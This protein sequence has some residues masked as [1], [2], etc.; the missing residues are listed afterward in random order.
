MGLQQLTSVGGEFWIDNNDLLTDLFPN[1]NLTFV[2]EYLYIINNALLTNLSG[3]ENIDLSSI[4]ELG[5]YDNPMLSECDAQSICD[6]LVSPNGTINIHDNASGCNS[7]TEVED[8]CEDN[9][10]PEGIEFE[11]QSSIDNFQSNYPG[12]TEIE[13]DVT[14]GK[15]MISSNITNLDGLNVITAIGGYLDIR[16][17][18]N[19]INLN[20]LSNLTTVG[21]LV[22]IF[23]NNALTDLSGLDLLTNVG[24]NLYISYNDA[25]TNLAGLESLLF[26]GGDLDIRENGSLQSLIGLNSLT[27]IEGSLEIRANM[28]LTSLSEL[29]GLIS[30]GNHLWIGGNDILVSLT[31]LEGISTLEGHLLINYNYG[32]LE[33]TGL[34]NLT[35]IRGYLELRDN[36]VLPNLEGLDNLVSIGG[37]M[38]MRN[39]DALESITALNGLTSIGA[40]FRVSDNDLLTSLSG[41]EN[42]EA[43]SISDLYIHDN[44]VLTSCDIE[45][46]CNYLADPNGA[47]YINNNAIG[48]YDQEEV[49]EACFASVE[50]I[51][52]NEH[53]SISPNPALGTTHLRYTIYEQACLPARQGFTIFELFH[54]SGIKI[55]TILNEVKTPGTYELEVDLN[56]LPPGVYF[57]TLK[58]NEGMLTRKIIKL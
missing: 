24:E 50:E 5:I 41:L 8:D 23:N 32:L 25:L 51:G 22:S 4:N 16:L 14:I 20:G 19:L 42:I 1:N 55:K 18:D 38:E 27:T 34:N 15:F 11:T 12:C 21:G 10:L 40:E 47:I 45:S 36:Y 6:Y 56:D 53:F 9:C 57:C 7:Q 31:G 43:A 44:V 46:V 33:L 17:N 13:G 52:L 58:T 37:Y 54:I 26:L 35:S 49:E 3:L 39:N 30:V 29:S 28:S 48:C 2:G